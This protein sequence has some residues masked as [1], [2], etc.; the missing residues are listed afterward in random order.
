MSDKEVEELVT[1]SEA[2]IQQALHPE[3]GERMFGHVLTNHTLEDTTNLL[4]QIVS[5]YH[6]MVCVEMAADTVPVCER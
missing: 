1:A 6:P 5:Q 3:E 4:M 2:A